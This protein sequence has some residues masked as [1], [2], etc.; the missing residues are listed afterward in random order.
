VRNTA[1]YTLMAVARLQLGRALALDG[2]KTRAKAHY[3]NFLAVR[4]EADHDIPL[5]KQTKRNTSNCNYQ[6]E[7]NNPSNSRCLTTSLHIK[8]RAGR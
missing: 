4:N 7:N 5:L 1:V 6:P 3:Q 8:T 2:D